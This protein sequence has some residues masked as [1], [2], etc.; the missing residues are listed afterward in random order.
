MR[1]A[2][3]YNESRFTTVK[4]QEFVPTDPPLRLLRGWSNDALAKMDEGFSA[5]C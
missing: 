3:G 1:G 2:D 5:M 4:L